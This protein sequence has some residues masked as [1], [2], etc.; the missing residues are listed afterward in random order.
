[1]VV[2][3]HL[4]KNLQQSTI[5]SQ[6]PSVPYTDPVY[7]ITYVAKKMYMY[8]QISCILIVAMNVFRFGKHHLFVKSKMVRKSRMPKNKT[9]RLACYLFGC[10]KFFGTPRGSPLTCNHERPKYFQDPGSP[11]SILIHCSIISTTLRQAYKRANSWFRF[12][13][14][15]NQVS[16][17]NVNQVICA[18]CNAH[19]N[20][21]VI[22]APQAAISLGKSL[23]NLPC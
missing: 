20:W 10:W 12:Q 15:V 19:V 22:Q 9:P 5:T 11:R 7:N 3:V 17:P 21:K 2:T 8:T 1:M 13:I 23:A 18:K 16:K 4:K 6:V 14:E